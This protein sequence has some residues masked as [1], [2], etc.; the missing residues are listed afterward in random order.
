MYGSKF[1]KSKEDIELIWS[2]V[3]LFAAILFD[4]IQCL[5]NKMVLKYLSPNPGRATKSI[6]KS[7]N[8]MNIGRATK[9]INKSFNEMNIGSMLSRL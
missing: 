9:S 8:E 1:R 6:N 3:G 5:K 7:F 2:I 4:K